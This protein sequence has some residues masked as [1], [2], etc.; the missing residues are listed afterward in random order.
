MQ[1]WLLCKID[2]SAQY[3]Y[4]YY[5][6]L[7]HEDKN[8]TILSY[9]GK[10]LWYSNTLFGELFFSS[11]CK[12]NNFSQFIW[13]TLTSLNWCQFPLPRNITESFRP[14]WDYTRGVLLSPFWSGDNTV[15]IR[16]YLPVE[17]SY[18]F[19][20]LKHW[21]QI[22]PNKNNTLKRFLMKKRIL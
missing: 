17:I 13:I 9:S 12:A 10:L 11:I 6:Q 2:S 19:S 20:V 22:F 3:S 15:L 18:S 1:W 16:W 21:N 5:L 8:L 4:C 14:F 7:S